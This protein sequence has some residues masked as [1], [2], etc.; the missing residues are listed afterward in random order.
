MPLLRRDPAVR[1]ITTAWRALTTETN[2]PRIGPGEPTLIACSGGADSSALAIALASVPRA[3]TRFVIAH[4]VHDLRPESESLPDRDA[5]RELALR[6][7]LEF[8]EASIAV[9]SHT[10]NAE[11][12]ARTLRY[13]ALASLARERDLR[14]IATAHHAGD[15]LE[16]MLAAL[17]RGAG[18]R[19]LAGIPTRRPLGRT[20][21]TLIRPMLAAASAGSAT[22]DHVESQRLCQLA[23]WVWN[24]DATNTDTSRLRAALRHDVI[25]RLQALR[26]GF[27]A[28]ALRSAGI[29]RDAAELIEEHSRAHRRAASLDG[30]TLVWDRASL[31]PLPAVILGDLLRSAASELI[32]HLR[33]DARALRSL[34]PAIDAI[35][36]VGTD[37][38]SFALAGVTVLVT[39]A[40][41]TIRPKDS[42]E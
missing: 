23:G 25:P 27:G 30:S 40:R 10:G 31:R 2:E 37:P 18:P 7:G 34:A 4:I 19:G 38:R 15:H 22:V 16:T 5:A 35:R 39:S 6:L 29:L 32:G 20:G 33:A 41:V 8:A 11:A 26:P 17:L 42:A 24:E 14:F 36:D 9:R 28:R 13:A 3:R 1:A 12:T 21:L